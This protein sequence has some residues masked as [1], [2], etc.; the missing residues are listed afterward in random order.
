MNK[1]KLGSQAQNELLEFVF[2]LKSQSENLFAKLYLMQKLH[3]F[4]VNLK[5]MLK[6][7]LPHPVYAFAIWRRL[8]F[9]SSGQCHY[10]EIR[11]I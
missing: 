4:K 10:I 2:V 6:T 11:S 5:L 3:F 9:G 7:K 8:Q 1:D